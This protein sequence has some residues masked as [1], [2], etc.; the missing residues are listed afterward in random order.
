MFAIPDACAEFSA[1]AA[2]AARIASALDCPSFP[3]SNRDRTS[4]AFLDGYSTI[5]FGHINTPCQRRSPNGGF[6]IGTAT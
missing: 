3:L 5:A 2:P 1:A 4:P 6:S